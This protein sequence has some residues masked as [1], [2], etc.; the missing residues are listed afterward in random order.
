MHHPVEEHHQECSTGDV[1][2]CWECIRE[3]VVRRPNCRDHVLEIASALN[4]SD[5]CPLKLSREKRKETDHQSDEGTDQDGGNATPHTKGDT[6]DD[7]EGNVIHGTDTTVTLISC[8]LREKRYLVR[9]MTPP[10]IKKPKKQ[11]GIAWRAV[12]PIPITV[13]IVDQRGGASMSLHPVRVL[14]TNMPRK[15]YNS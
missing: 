6:S 10:Q 9:P 14:D 13:E 11:M 15:T 4:C 12:N 1:C 3:I 5:C 2:A 8:G 7:G